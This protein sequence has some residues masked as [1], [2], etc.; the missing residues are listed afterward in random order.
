MIKANSTVKMNPERIRQL[1]RAAVT[2]V[3]QTGEAL[4]KEMIRAQVVPRDTGYLQ[5]EAFFADHS[6]SKAGI[7]TLIHSAPYARRLYFHPEYNFRKHVN[8]NAKGQWFEDWEKGG[9]RDTFASAE[10]KKFY[11][12]AGGV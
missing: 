7:V 10:F 9:S 11:K 5:G 8:A 12:K 4:H 1:S 6:E 2:A 3:E